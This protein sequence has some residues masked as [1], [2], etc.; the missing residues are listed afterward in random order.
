MAVGKLA[1]HARNVDLPVPLGDSD[2][3]HGLFAGPTI[4]AG[5]GQIYKSVMRS[6]ELY[7]RDETLPNALLIRRAVFRQTEWR[8]SIKFR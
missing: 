3:L 1:L 6:S 5:A 2:P 4:R 7:L 8:A